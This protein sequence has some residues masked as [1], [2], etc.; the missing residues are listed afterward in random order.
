[1]SAALATA[2]TLGAALSR[3]RTALRDAG[4]ESA[5]LDARLLV[6]AAAAVPVE[7]VIAYPERAL[8]PGAAE[9]LQGWQARRL[10]RE[11]MAYI[12]GRRE[13]WSLDF[14]VT[15]A[16]LMPRPDSETLVAAV[17]DRIGERQAP[18]RVIDFG[19]GTGCLLLALL[20]E[21][22]AA[23]GIGVD[24][25]D[26]ALAVARGNAET[27]G[28]ATRATFVRGDWGA[29]LAGMFDVVISNPPYI[30]THQL[31]TLS[32][33]VRHEP[34]AAL[35]GGADGLTAYRRLMP[36][37]ARLLAKGGI[38]AVEVGD[39][40]AAD[41]E[42]LGVAAGLAAAGRAAD[43]GGIERSILFRTKS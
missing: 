14:T 34:E 1:V 40:Q 6:A 7:T 37:V 8:P 27:L 26:P 9:R 20:S 22:P 13:F 17:L 12:L 35:D 18:L 5:A 30:A 2:D 23:S 11:P 3:V 31:A 42:A 38:A 25:S 4:I 43:L 36:D 21:L 32:P 39:G 10:A 19:T 16:T 29:G 33:E 28:L 41:V 24:S 15:P